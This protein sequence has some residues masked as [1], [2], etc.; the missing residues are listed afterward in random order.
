MSASFSVTSST[1]SYDVTV[2]AG[3]F[4]QSAEWPDNA[5]LLAALEASKSLEQLPVLI[6]RLR[7]AGVD[8]GTTLIAVGGGIIQ[9]ITGFAAS[10]YMRGLPWIYVP[11]T[12]LAMVDSCIGGK[13]SINVGPYKN[14][15]GTFHPPQHI[16][17]DPLLASTLPPEQFAAGLI[18]AAK[19]CFCCGSQSFTR[20]LSYAPAPGMPSAALEEVILESLQAKKHFIERDEFDKKERLLLNFGHT[21]GHALEG[22]SHYSIPHGIAVGLGILCSL[23][24]QQQRGI[25]ADVLQNV[26]KLKLHLNKL[27]RTLPN[28]SHQLSGLDMDELLNRFRSDKKH[29][30]DTFSLILVS[31]DGNVQLERILRS[32]DVERDLLRTF[33]TMRETYTK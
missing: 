6:E 14:L 31:M 8:R 2:A 30:A 5:I 15:V 3:L 23:I 9:D 33:E 22:A 11:T 25:N 20:Y 1:G 29:R 16:R 32:P 7:S 12:V 13:S 19:I 28:L 17:I 26:A 21:F 27:I 10:V 4:A 24:F 18:E